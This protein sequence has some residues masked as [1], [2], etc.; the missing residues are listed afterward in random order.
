MKCPNCQNYILEKN[1]FSK[2][3]KNYDGNLYEYNAVFYFCQGCE[4][5]RNEDFDECDDPN[6]MSD[7]DDREIF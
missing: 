1:I 2:F 3:D 5:W 6:V 7:Y 4:K